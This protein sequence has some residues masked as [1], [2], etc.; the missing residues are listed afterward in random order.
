MSRIVP[1]PP[2]LLPGVLEA[3]AED[4][5]E[6]EVVVEDSVVGTVEVGGVSVLDDT[7]MEV[8]LGL[9]FGEDDAAGIVDFVDVLGMVVEVDDGDILSR[10]VGTCVEVDVGMVVVLV[11][12]EVEESSSSAVLLGAAEAFE[13]TTY[14]VFTAR[15]C[16][17]VVCGA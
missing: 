3:S 12:V 9:L 4:V 2:L 5:E 1:P 10:L 13:S 11:Y 17:V 7:L 15:F 8:E 6:E 14:C 16:M